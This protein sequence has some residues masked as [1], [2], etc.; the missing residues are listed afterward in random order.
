MEYSSSEKGQSFPP[1]PWCELALRATPAIKLVQP[2]HVLLRSAHA[3]LGE[4]RVAPWSSSGDSFATRD[5]DNDDPG[6]N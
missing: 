1:A 4:P 2:E 5:H 6:Y 3:V